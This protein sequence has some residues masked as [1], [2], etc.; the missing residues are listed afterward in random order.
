MILYKQYYQCTSSNYTSLNMEREIH[1][2]TIGK[3][4]VIFRDLNGFFCLRVKY[5]K[6]IYVKAS[7][8][9]VQFRYI[10]KLHK[11]IHLQID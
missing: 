7:S 4:I 10:V 1:H 3:E 11:L 6:N 8:Y 2:Y 9:G 5:L